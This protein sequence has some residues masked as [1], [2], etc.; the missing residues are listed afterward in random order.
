MIMQRTVQPRS[1]A[2][3]ALLFGSTGFSLA[4]CDIGIVGRECTGGT[5]GVCDGDEYCAF[6]PDAAC[7]AADKVG[8]C[9]P[10][11][12]ACDQ[13][14]EPVCGCDDV[15][16]SNECM[17]ASAGVSVAAQGECNPSPGGVCGGIAGIPCDA[18]EYCDYGD[19]ATC[20]DADLQGMCAPLPEACEDIYDPVCACD[21]RT[22]GN[23]CEAAAAGISITTP[24][25][26]APQGTACGGLLG[27]ECA[28][29]EFCN[30]PP[31][32]ICGAADQTGI[33][34]AIPE[35]CTLEYAPVCGCDDQ[36]YGNACAAAAA[37]VSVLREGACDEPPPEQCTADVLCPAGYYCEYVVPNTCDADVDV[38]TCTPAPEACGE[39]YDPVCSCDGR[40]F[41]NP[42]EAR[43]A[44]V[45][46]WDPGE[47][48][49]VPED[50]C[51]GIQG[52]V[53]PEDQYCDYGPEATC[54]DADLLGKCEPLPEN[55]A[56]IDDPVC[57]C[58]NQTFSNACLAAAAGYS[59][60]VPGA[61]DMGSGEQCGGIAG[62][63][64]PEGEHCDYG[65]E[66]TCQGAD[67]LG[68]CVT[69]P[70]GCTREYVPVCA[71]D[72]TTYGNACEA[73]AA[74][75][76]IYTEGECDAVG[77]PC[78]GLTPYPQDCGEGAICV[79]EPEAI[80]AALDVPGTCVALPEECDVE[81]PVCACGG[82][83]FRNLCEAAA[84]GASIADDS[85][86]CE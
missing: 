83:T 42:C 60:T 10:R 21:G 85:G 31:E 8:T 20:Q 49:E 53:C 1:W 66:A 9:E 51:G 6:P 59:I 27:L 19:E 68:T 37:G 77:R 75:V 56:L 25:E 7:G 46:Q 13:V 39:I 74:G 34:T 26:C 44:G 16:Y 54:S 52:L 22:F 48:E 45:S 67:Y 28:D 4:S 58:D 5:A 18:G 76:S 29:G 63:P 3:W 40:T 65:P 24:G 69:T 84:A 64:C 72:G 12:D 62:L 82:E 55:C 61:C 71:C 47:C 38:G 80:C 57:T 30:Y 15:T 17:A 33:C 2:M 36:T 32:A 81:A 35:G 79:F 23:S 43:A 11:P 50:A 14:Y 86:P 78:G 73:A 70:T 41:S